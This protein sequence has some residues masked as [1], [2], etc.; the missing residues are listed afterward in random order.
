MEVVLA[1][2]EGDWAEFSLSPPEIKQILEEHQMDIE[3][4]GPVLAKDRGK[5]EHISRRFEDEE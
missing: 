5:S 1:G 2:P 3:L 4:T